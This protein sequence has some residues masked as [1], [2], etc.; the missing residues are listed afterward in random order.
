[1]WDIARAH[2]I[3]VASLAGYNNISSR[4]RIY[5]GQILKVP[6]A[7]STSPGSKRTTSAK[8]AKYK[9]R[10]GDNLWVIAMKYG[11]SVSVL[12]RLNKLSSRGRIYPGQSLKVP[13]SKTRQGTFTYVVRRGDNLSRI[14]VHFGV[15]VADI[16][17]RNKLS[18]PERIAIGM[19][20]LIPEA[21]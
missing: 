1:M 7:N 14:A 12:T 11:T 5:P 8:Y 4:R 6:G 18:N 10:S 13:T 2:H 20:L 16:L 3:S 17:S 9:V 21:R 15:G 19:K